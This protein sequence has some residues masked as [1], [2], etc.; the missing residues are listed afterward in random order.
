MQPPLPCGVEVYVRG[1]SGLHNAKLLLKNVTG[2]VGYYLNFG[3][4]DWPSSGGGRWELVERRTAK[5]SHREGRDD[6]RMAVSLRLVQLRVVLAE[7]KPVDDERGIDGQPTHWQAAASSQLYNLRTSRETN[8]TYAA[9]QTVVGIKSRSKAKIPVS[10]VK[11]CCNVTCSRRDLTDV[12]N[13]TMVI[14]GFSH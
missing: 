12:N 13:V 7:W 2:T 6:V 9:P 10:S 11:S 14:S 4:T 5:N 3:H 1:T 8:G